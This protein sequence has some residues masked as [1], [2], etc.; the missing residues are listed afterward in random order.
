MVER[1]SFVRRLGR[2]FGASRTPCRRNVLLFGWL[3][4]KRNFGDGCVH[5]LRIRSPGLRSFDGRNRLLVF[6]YWLGLTAKQR[7]QSKLTGR[8]R[9]NAMRCRSILHIELG[10]LLL[11]WNLCAE[12]IS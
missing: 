9:V 10:F 2:S 8:G 3:L 12:C 5:L 1:G 11:F 7:R 4:C 6:L